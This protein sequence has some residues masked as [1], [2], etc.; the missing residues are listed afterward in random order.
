MHNTDLQEIKATRNLTNEAIANHD[1]QTLASFWLDNIV[2]V[3]GNGDIIINKNIAEAVWKDIFEKQPEVSFVRN[4]NEII[5]SK[6]N[7]IAWE[8]GSWNGINAY[9]GGGNYSAMWRKQ[10]NKWKLQAELFVSFE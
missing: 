2:I 4:P 3:R 7:L 6:N 8:T 9:N 5:V 1:L 10:N